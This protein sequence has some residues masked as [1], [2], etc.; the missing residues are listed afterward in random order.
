[1]INI[2]RFEVK[3]NIGEINRTST[4]HLDLSSICSYEIE[5]IKKRICEALAED[6]PNQLMSTIGIPN[7]T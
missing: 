1:M 6:I 3:D 4:L 7:K 2:I 5:F